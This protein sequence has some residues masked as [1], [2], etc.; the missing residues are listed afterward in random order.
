MTAA[1]LLA[2]LR[3]A[4][5]T[6]EV[7]DGRLK[8][9][10]PAGA[11]SDALR[12]DIR[13]RRDDLITLLQEESQ[14]PD[15]EPIA[16]NDALPLSR[17]QR[18]LWIIC[19]L[20]GPNDPAYGLAAKWHIEETKSV[21]LLSAAL[22]DL[23]RRHEILRTIYPEV[24]GEP[25]AKILPV[26]SISIGR[27][28]LDASSESTWIHQVDDALAALLARPFDL[29]LEPSFR[30][31]IVTSPKGLGLVVSSHHIA[32][33]HWSFSLLRQELSRSI[34]ALSDHRKIAAPSLQYVDYAS[35]QKRK[36]KGAPLGQHLDWWED[37]LAN[38]P[39]LCVFPPD[40][41]GSEN[42]EWRI[43][44]FDWDEQLASELRQL[45]RGH[46]VTQYMV[47]LAVCAVA[48]R[49]HTGQSDIVLGS[50]TG[51]RERS[52]LETMIGPFVNV[53]AL[54]LDLDDDPSFAV[55]LQRARD[56]VLDAYAHSDAPFEM[57]VE[58]LNP[59][60]S[61]DHTPL[62]QVAVIMHTAS[63]GSITNIAGGG[64]MYDLTWFARDT[65]T[66]L[67]M[68]ME[69]RSDLYSPA[70][71]ARVASHLE[72]IL[73]AGIADPSR[74]IS[75]IP[76]DDPAE[77]L[78][79]ALALQPPIVATALMPFPIAFEQQVART[80]DR[81][82][83]ST[84]FTVV[85]YSELD[86]T[87]NR[88]ARLLVSAGVQPRDR[89]GIFADRTPLM[90]ASLIG[91]LK[92]GA[93]Y[94]PLDPALP[95]ARLDFMV[96]DSGIGIVLAD[97][98]LAQ[99]AVALKRRVLHLNELS[100][101]DMDGSALSCPARAEDPAYVIYTSGSTGRPNGVVVPHGALSNFLSS[102][103]R[104]PGLN[105]D[106]VVASITTISFDI[107]V[108]ENFAPLIVGARIELMSRDTVTDGASLAE[109]L[110][111][112]G[113]TVLQA[114]PATWRLLLE[115]GWD[116][117]HRLKALCGG[118]GLPRDL[119]DAL[120]MRVSELWNLYGPT[121][122]TVW[123]TA[124][125]LTRGE[126][127]NI[128]RPIDNTQVYIVNEHGALVPPGITGEIIIGGLGVTLGYHDRPELTAARFIPDRFG[129]ARESRLY[130]TG[131]LGMWNGEKLIHLGRLDQ[132][133]KI[134]GFRVELD[135]IEIAL[136]G[137]P[138]VKQAAVTAHGASPTKHI[139]AYCVLN[140]GASLT[141]REAREHLRL[142]LPSYM[143]P[144]FVEVIDA[145]PLTPNGKVDRKA[146]PSPLDVS[147][148]TRSDFVPCAPG[149]ETEL[150]KIWSE[151]LSVESVGANDN[152][153]EI[154]GHSLL[155]LRVARA[156][157]QR[158]GY[159]M[160]PRMLFTQSLKNIAQ[161][162]KKISD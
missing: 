151:V 70:A 13:A 138:A 142:G 71:I 110:S 2:R 14:Q 135:E 156:V 153:F 113:A 57:V 123:S 127:V 29:T 25:V 37:K 158:M 99:S 90:I 81:V 92:L 87:A 101:A 134:R 160:E 52:E 23:N 130:R 146:L 143:I 50:S 133:V 141:A 53:F 117:S 112:S 62:F 148:G 75:R 65:G 140:E 24:A 7:S 111:V 88:I 46:R 83:V 159:Q 26:G 45:A 56:T 38:P 109:R 162:L 86:A 51:T 152:F 105:G 42:Q 122:T 6:V 84:P 9:S 136:A 120:L 116:G 19:Q 78:R 97:T 145:I 33:D 59:S 93:T 54:R 58:R 30:W 36:E 102:M 154:G 104:E 107:A 4:G 64:A 44:G 147:S 41:V 22:H 82:A 48:L 72:T 103:I 39:A 89:V 17:F 115:A 119:A 68:G 114:T 47:L 10:A 8:V 1:Q 11:L 131:D 49:L 28:E 128:G 125:R 100:L 18:R 98:A 106:D 31:Q 157:T 69:Y 129:L 155:S 66:R 5:I 32:I 108:L 132:Q 91:V 96:G 80:P 40:R 35:W 61:F 63:E 79:T 74:P 16:R 67:T 118:E 150:A 77:V 85:T 126:P 43:F 139:V 95:A 20:R 76:L 124:G 15:L 27:I 94:V 55:L 21:D 60:R 137:H 149:L 161:S 144:S 12:E 73:R 121:E 3:E 34:A